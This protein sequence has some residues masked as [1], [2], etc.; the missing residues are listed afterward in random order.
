MQT[1][2]ANFAKDPAAGPGWPILGSAELDVGDLGGDGAFGEY[3]IGAEGIDRA[4]PV[5]AALLAVE[6]I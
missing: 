5:Y 1:A 4:C 3:D 6:G 2:W